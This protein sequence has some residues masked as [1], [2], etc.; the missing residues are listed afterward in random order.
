MS[1]GV[2]SLVKSAFTERPGIG[3]LADCVHYSEGHD[4]LLRAGG[5]WRSDSN[6]DLHSRLFCGKGSAVTTAFVRL[7]GETAQTLGK[8][9]EPNRGGGR[10]WNGTAYFTATGSTFDAYA[11]KWWSALT[12][13]A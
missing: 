7:L 12:T 2:W 8:F 9:A 1:V 11:A 13:L 5:W 6:A 3:A 10:M 4:D